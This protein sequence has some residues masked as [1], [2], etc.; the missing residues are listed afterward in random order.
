MAR[1]KSFPW[2]PTTWGVQSGHAPTPA[3]INRDGVLKNVRLL[4]DN[5]GLVVAYKG[6][7]SSYPAIILWPTDRGGGKNRY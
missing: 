5:L 4:D 2:W 7:A 3:E 6:F 1:L